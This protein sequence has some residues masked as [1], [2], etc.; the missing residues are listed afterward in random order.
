VK[1]DVIINV[2]GKP[3]QTAL[4]L[5]TLME[6][7]GKWIDKI[8]YQEE[9]ELPPF[10]VGLPA[11]NF[12]SIYGKRVREYFA[13]R[14]VPFVPRHFNFTLRSNQT[15]LVRDKEYRLSMRYQHGFENSD[16]D[17]VFLAHNDIQV[18]GDVV[19]SMLK[20]IDGH[21]GIGV[22]GT[23]EICPA[24]NLGKCDRTAYS[25]YRPDYSE[26]KTLYEKFEGHPRY[27]RRYDF[28]N[29]DFRQRPW[30]LPECRLCEWACLVN[31]KMTRPLT[32]PFGRGTPIG[33][34]PSGGG[35]NLDIGAAWFRDMNAM[36]LRFK[37]FDLSNFVLHSHG[38]M[39]LCD[40]RLHYYYEYRALKVL[41]HKYPDFLR[42]PDRRPI[43]K[44]P[45]YVPAAEPQARLW[46]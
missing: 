19:G 8:Y 42:L 34:Y 36:G 3:L 30:P 22:I 39:T 43:E 28:F 37:H 46:L 21:A 2:Y 23:C 45:E 9:P 10:E 35:S 40:A 33:T 14:L 29:A 6:H 12:I 13:D 26:L 44:L 25:E 11:D 17:F 18:T 32:M 31:L 38:H 5:L 7:S 20:H 1:V 16:K 24:G 41:K 15:R 27:L 4:S